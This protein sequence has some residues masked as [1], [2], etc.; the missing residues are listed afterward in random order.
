MTT[1][2]AQEIIQAY[3][4]YERK[5]MTMAGSQKIVT[6]EIVKFVTTSINGSF[7]AY[8][9]LDA[10]DVDRAIQAEIAYFTQLRR[11]FEWKS[12]DFDRPANIGERLVAHG[13][14]AGEAEAFM[15][16]ELASIEQPLLDS[17]GCVK[18][19]DVEG[20]KDAIAVQEQVWG[21][22]FSGQLTHLVNVQQ[23]TPEDIAIYVVYADGKPVSSAWIVY[24]EASPFASIW[25]GSTLA[26][27]RGR[28]YYSVLLH[29]RINDAKQREKRYLTIDASPMSRPIV[30]KHGFRF[31]A[32]TIPY[33]FEVG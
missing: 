17:G 29:K 8:F 32:M 2:N 12:Y 7:I 18:V 4:Q 22:D 6:P 28:G 3:N 19:T 5:G 25:G 21:G 16:L 1:L 23:A 14:A 26:D 11:N 27:Y 15:V 20:I 30:A 24:N 10:E 13:F 9:A 31:V 33:T